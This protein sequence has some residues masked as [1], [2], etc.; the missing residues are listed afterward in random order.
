M[1]ADHVS[2]PAARP[3]AD[4]ACELD[5]AIEITE[6]GV[7]DRLGRAM[8]GR[9]RELPDGVEVRFRAEAWDD[10]LR[11]VEV[12]SQCCPFLDLSAAKQDDAVVL[13]V[14]GRPE[15]HDVIA[16]IFAPDATR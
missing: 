14:T 15:A 16:Q 1:S 13:S 12:E 2:R 7:R 11:Y 6:E 10:V 9:P 3:D 4:L 8:L 5:I